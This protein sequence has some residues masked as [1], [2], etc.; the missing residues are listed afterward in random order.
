MR[1]ACSS[2]SRDGQFAAEHVTQRRPSKETLSVNRHVLTVSIPRNGTGRTL[3]SGWIELNRTVNG[4]I[5][6]VRTEQ[7][8]EWSDQ[9][10]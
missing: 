2:C 5:R 7:E 4:A 1:I 9:I 3:E 8:G 6:L 10:G